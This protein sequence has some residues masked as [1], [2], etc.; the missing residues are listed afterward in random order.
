VKTYV[1]DASALVNFIADSAGAGRVQQLFEEAYRGHLALL[2]S[3]VNVGEVFY[4]A[5]QT[6]GEEHARSVIDLVSRLPF[7]MIPV[8]LE[9]SLKAGEIK[10]RH[11]LPYVDC[12]A[13]SLAML[14]KATLVT[15]DDDFAK[16]GRHF[17]ILWLQRR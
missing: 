2:A 4:K 12:I 5:W 8:D 17:H 14:R 6:E 3:V 7:A 1:L 16:L 9:Q 13:A 11:K 10:A 15:S